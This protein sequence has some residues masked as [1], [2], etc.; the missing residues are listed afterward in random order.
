MY[1]RIPRKSIF[2]TNKYERRIIWLALIPALL[3]CILVTFVIIH[4]TRQLEDF[5][6]YLTKPEILN[7]IEN[8]GY[9][10]IGA[11]W[12]L[13][14]IIFF[15]ALI[16]SGNLVGAFVRIIREL[17]DFIAGKEHKSIRARRNDDLANDLLKRIN[18]LIKNIVMHKGGGTDL[19]QS[20]GL[21]E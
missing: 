7:I 8:W 17:D 5:M 18:I 20:D 16:V 3:F 14:I 4:L 11:F 21:Q 15:W 6:I 2:H 13:F 9:W 1:K 19:N 12:L 10:I